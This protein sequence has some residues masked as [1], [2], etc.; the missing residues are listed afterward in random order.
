MMDADSGADSSFMNALAASGD[1]A[2]GSP[3]FIKGVDE[4]LP[5]ARVTFDKFHVVAHA[6]AAVDKM[7]R[8]EQKSDPG[9]KGLRWA[10]L[11]DHNKLH[12]E[13]HHDLDALV[14][15]FT[16]KRTARAWLY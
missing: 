13:Q 6:S 11:K 5:N 12:A 2:A 8:L 10:L 15:R 14:A 9:L 7:R 16:S 3:A 4:H 1:R